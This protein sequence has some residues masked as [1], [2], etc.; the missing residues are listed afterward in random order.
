MGYYSRRVPWP[1]HMLIDGT[2]LLLGSPRATRGGAPTPQLVSSKI[3]DISQVAP[4]DYSYG[5]TSPISDR[6]Q[7]Y[8]SLALGMGLR[9]QEKWQ[10]FRYAQAMGV[11]CSVWP[12]CKG[13]EPHPVMPPTRDGANGIRAF[14]ELGPTLYAANGRYILRRDADAT[15]TVVKDFGAGT[16]VLNVA[17]FTSN[18]DGVKRAWVALSSGPA[19]YSS[20][21][22][23][24]TPMATFTALA[25]LPLGREWWWAD[26]VNRLRKCDTNADPTV[27][28]NY[29]S[30]MF[31][32]G[33]K[34]SPI[35][36]LAQTA[37]GTMIVLKTDG[38]YTL[39][40]AGDDHSLY[41]FLKFAPR[42][43]N[44]KWLGQFEN[45]LY[46]SYGLAFFRLNPDLSM[47]EVGP[48]RLI[49][50]DGPVR[51]QITAF[52][53]VGGMFAYAMLYNPDSQNSYLM[54]FGGFV[55][56]AQANQTSPSA[57]RVDAWHGA[58]GHS[59]PNVVGQALHVS[60]VGAPSGHTRTYLGLSDGTLAYYTNPC[61]PNPSACSVYT[62][63][64][65][66]GWVELPYWH[67]GYHA[68]RKSLRH[69]AVTG[70]F[71]DASNFVSVD[72]KLDPT[73]AAWTD[74]PNVFDSMVYEESTFPTTAVA[75]LAAFRVHLENLAA[76]ESP[77]VSSVAIGH[78]LRPQRYMS[79][80]ADILCA[81]GLVRRD[82]VPLRIGRQE[83]QAAV[84]R[85]VDNPGAVT[86]T[87]PNERTEQLS[88]TDYTVSQAFDEIGRTWRGSL[89]VKAVQWSPEVT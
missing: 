24:W 34:S 78:A 30:L 28:A 41:P 8:E 35:T 65:G 67:G 79:F 23:T 73:A 2:G 20:D 14:F 6:Q 88:F 76:A 3:Q 44:G 61:T 15:W 63:E 22:T 9:L 42:L 53:G 4:P 11:D 83:I 47:E 86:V 52:T 31:N 75:V 38:I 27:E 32:V 89:R 18:F 58:L 50:N 51:G 70:T 59:L 1:Y 33:D 66:D 84:E 46:V 62:F 37:A 29:T 60:S 55:S 39:D 69:L 71:L 72:Y 19:Q 82:G 7:P 43:D 48:E 77:L 5:G 56:G 80:E 25:F 87:L 57:S 54:K 16:S 21:G 10:D 64:L 26:D 81:D 68:S 13:P 36:N 45:A 85:A 12:W 17:V 74:L 49:S 40:Q